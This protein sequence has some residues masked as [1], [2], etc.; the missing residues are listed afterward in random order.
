MSE[1][2]MEKTDWVQ[3]QLFSLDQVTD[4][5]VCR[6][7]LGKET[8]LL[9]HDGVLV[10]IPG[11]PVLLA[12]VVVGVAT[13]DQVDRVKSQIKATELPIVIQRIPLKLQTLRSRV[14]EGLRYLLRDL[15]DESVKERQVNR[16]EL[17]GI[18]ANKPVIEQ[19]TQQ[20]FIAQFNLTILPQGQFTCRVRGCLES[21]IYD[22]VS[23]LSSG[24]RVGLMGTLDCSEKTVAVVVNQ[25]DVL[26]KKLD[27][28]AG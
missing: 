6:V 14:A 15:N 11:V 28:E 1:N 20:K 25:L 23:S 13:D 18:L 3:V 12:G 17:T 7:V 26:S 9:S 10:A 16:L 8:Q 22:T 24:Q 4:A 27:S 21:T 19:I 2:V 5:L